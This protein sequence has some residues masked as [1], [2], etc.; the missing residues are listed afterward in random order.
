MGSVRGSNEVIY[1]QVLCM[2][3]RGRSLANARFCEDVLVKLKLQEA[4]P[5]YSFQAKLNPIPQK[6]RDFLESAVKPAPSLDSSVFPS[7]DSTSVYIMPSPRLKPVGTGHFISH[8][9]LSSYDFLSLYICLCACVIKICP[10]RVANAVCV[11]VFVLPQPPPS[12]PFLS[13]YYTVP[14]LS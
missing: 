2:P 9:V 12:L 10:C 14:V 6:S 7:V 1:A 11:A 13:G 3:C 5:S 4:F 8:F